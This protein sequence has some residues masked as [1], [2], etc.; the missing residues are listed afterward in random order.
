MVVNEYRITDGR[1]W[2]RAQLWWE[3]RAERELGNAIINPINPTMST[4]TMQYNVNQLNA[5][6]CQ[7]T[8]CNTVSTNAMQYKANQCNAIQ[9]QPMQ[10]NSMSTNARSYNV[11]ALHYMHCTTMKSTVDGQFHWKSRAL[12]LIGRS[13]GS[14][15]CKWVGFHQPLVTC[16]S[17][18]LTWDECSYLKLFCDKLYKKKTQQ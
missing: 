15:M 4:N 2:H 5:I 16:E 14:V 12:Y 1:C 10:C 3:G 13:G 18:N 17:K 8:Q 6:Q 9:C 7:P 11:N